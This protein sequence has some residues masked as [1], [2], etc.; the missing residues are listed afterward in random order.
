M[1]F[2]TSGLRG[3]V[4]ELEGHASALYATAFARHLLE[5]GMAKAGD[6]IYVA[7]D[8]RPSSPSIAGTCIAALAASG[9][10][11]VHCG[12]IPTPALALY[13]ALSAADIPK[14]VRLAAM[15]GVIREET[16]LSRPR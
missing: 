6:E 12:F 5:T 15:H 8:F 11:P 9:L 13:A 1:K 10:K 7:G 3:L 2:G 16:S 4:T 14:P